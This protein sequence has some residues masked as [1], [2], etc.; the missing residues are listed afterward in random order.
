MR[1]ATRIR[2]HLSDWWVYRSDWSLTPS[3]FGGLTY[4]ILGR[5]YADIVTINTSRSK[6]NIFVGPS[7]GAVIK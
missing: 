7:T 6:R 5:S 4:E 3:A 2:S 1:D